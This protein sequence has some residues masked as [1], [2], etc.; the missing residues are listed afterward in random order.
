MPTD[1][2]RLAAASRALRRRHGLTQKAL[3]ALGQSLHIQR[4]LETGQAGRLQ[5]DDLRG[6]FRRL[7][8]NVRVTVWYDGAT[9]DRLLDEDHASVVEAGIRLLQRYDWEPAS[10]ITFSEYGERGSIDLFGS[11]ESDRAVFVGEAKSA[12][13][14]LEETLRTFDAKV[15]LAPTIARKRLG[16]TPSVVGAAIILREDASARRVAQRHAATLGASYPAR[17]VE[18]RRWLRQP[19]GALR[20]LWFLSDPQKMEHASRR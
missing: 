20:G 10:E 11:R 2:Q 16:W 18:I 3:A 12:W 8:A 15:R 5:V 17:N 19:S 9:L 14:S 6:H 13:G 1:D 4:M 7:G